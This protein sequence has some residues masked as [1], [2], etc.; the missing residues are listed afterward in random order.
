MGDS[1]YIPKAKTEGIVQRECGER[2]WIIST[3]KG[4]L[5]R[6]QSHINQLPKVPADILPPKIAIPVP[7][8][9]S[10]GKSPIKERKGTVT[11]CSGRTVRPPAQR[12]AC[13]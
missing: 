8:P 2:I 13:E 9:N 7:P 5:R 3:P 12:L 4:D 11:T 10:A 6:N 1:V